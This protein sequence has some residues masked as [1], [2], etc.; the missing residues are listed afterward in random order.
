MRQWP[1]LV[2][3]QILVQ[4]LLLLLLVMVLLV[5][6]LLARGLH[7]RLDYHPHRSGQ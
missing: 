7:L 4:L 5:M 6:V 3:D 2:G 1:L